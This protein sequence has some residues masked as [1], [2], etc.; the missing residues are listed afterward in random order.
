M[1]KELAS[2]ATLLNPPHS[3]GLAP[4]QTSIVQIPTIETGQGLF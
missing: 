1:L 2:I 4:V 3:A